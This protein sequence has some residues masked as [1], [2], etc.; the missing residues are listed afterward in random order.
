M[1]RLFTSRVTC[2]VGWEDRRS[3]QRVTPAAN[4]A[5]S[6]PRAAAADHEGRC[7]MAEKQ[8]GAAKVA[9][10]N[11]RLAP[12][13]CRRRSGPRQSW[14][15][16]A[17]MDPSVTLKASHNLSSGRAGSA[18]ASPAHNWRAWSAS[19]ETPRERCDAQLPLCTLLTCSIA[20]CTTHDVHYNDT[21][22][23]LHRWAHNDSP[24][25]LGE[26]VGLPSWCPP[27]GC[28]IPM[29]P[30]PIRTPLACSD[31]LGEALGAPPDLLP[32]NCCSRGRHPT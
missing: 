8:E 20:M 17:S 22:T 25:A 15:R 12:F 23:R 19:A 13:K 32:R 6:P 18:R 9:D 11:G 30:I 16:G 3:G 28:Q 31:A 26:R 2:F 4:L 7:S 27:V 21:R 14:G 1:A 29:D 24:V 10:D 5:P